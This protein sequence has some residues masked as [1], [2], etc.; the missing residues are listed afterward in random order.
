MQGVIKISF[1]KKHFKAAC[2]RH[3]FSGHPRT[4]QDTACH[5][6]KERGCRKI[7]V[8]PKTDSQ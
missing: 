7:F 4:S 8:L 6:C 1:L 2:W 5:S 3:I